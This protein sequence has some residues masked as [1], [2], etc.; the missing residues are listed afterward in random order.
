MKLK[1]IK[2]KDTLQTFLKDVV[3]G[4]YGNTNLTNDNIEEYSGKATE[5]DLNE[6]EDFFWD[7]NS[8]LTDED[9]IDIE[10][11]EQHIHEVID[12]TV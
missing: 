5:Q 2:M 1:L 6:L 12:F 4:V 10:E 8:R 7:W 3:K 9:D 11:L